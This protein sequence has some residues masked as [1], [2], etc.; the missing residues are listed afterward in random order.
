MVRHRNSLTSRDTTKDTWIAGANCTSNNS[1]SL[2][3]IERISFD[4]FTFL[5]G[6]VLVS[7]RMIETE[8][9]NKS[10]AKGISDA[11]CDTLC[12]GTK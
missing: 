9:Y 7:G 3:K 1:V 11:Y 12:C 5:D 8:N 10:R 6:S 2:T 4:R